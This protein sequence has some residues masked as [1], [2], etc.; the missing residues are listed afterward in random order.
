MSTIK[1]APRGAGTPGEDCQHA[2]RDGALPHFRP[3]RE[4]TLRRPERGALSHLGQHGARRAPRRIGHA[5]AD[6]SSPVLFGIAQRRERREGGVPGGAAEL[7]GR[8][9]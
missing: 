5:A 4:W 1:N 9:K 7:R 3:R 6:E 2:L 8:G